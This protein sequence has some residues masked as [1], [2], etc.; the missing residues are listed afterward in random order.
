MNAR[1]QVGH[2]F[3][4]VGLSSINLLSR[5]GTYEIQSDQYGDHRRHGVDWYRG[6][7][8]NRP[9]VLFLYG[10]N[11]QSGERQDYRFVA[12]TLVR[13]GC[14]VAIPDY[15]LYPDVRFSEIFDDVQQV[16]G[17]VTQRM[18][19]NTGLFVMGHSA[20]AQMGALLALDRRINAHQCIDGFIG[21]AGPYDFYPFS[22][23]S[24]WDLFKQDAG[25][26]ESQPVNFVSKDAPPLYLLHGEDDRRVRR[27]HS[28]SL[29]EKQLSAGGKARR[30]V[31]QNMG[32]VDIIL[33]F[34]ALHRRRSKVVADVHA[35]IHS[36][37]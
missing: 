26:A 11:W 22:E 6:Q 30:E 27:G 21:L 28:K 36:T 13:L 33:S 1:A 4:R 37:A 18:A 8:G 3:Q 23:D 5:L 15:R 16:L 20:G 12:D 31:Y 2:L 10:G 34:S 29:M 25:Y 24:H 14:D 19:R 9:L 7:G 35:F 17:H 32:H